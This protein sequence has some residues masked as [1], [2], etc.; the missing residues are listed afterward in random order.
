MGIFDTLKNAILGHSLRAGPAQTGSSA[1]ASA[2]AT[3]A[4]QAGSQA[5]RPTQPPSAQPAA[6]SAPVDIESVLTQMA[7]KKPEKLNWQS[8]IVDLMK[9]VDLDPS[10]ENR[11]TLATELGYTG[12]TQDSASMNIWLHQEVMAKLAA[13][14]GKVPDSLRH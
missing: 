8:S 1:P 6:A 13:S 11:K 10:L 5:P 7:A 4:P 14:G 3:P 2:T 9:V 12:S